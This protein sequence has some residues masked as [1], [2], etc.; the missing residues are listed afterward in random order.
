MSKIVL[1]PN[2]A[3]LA[4]VT[5]LQN[6]WERGHLSEVGALLG[7]LSLLPDGKPADAAVTSDWNEAVR[8]ALSRTADANLKI[9]R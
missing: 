4:M 3:Y 7:S 9:S 6:Y 1:T 2:E 8:V 5:F